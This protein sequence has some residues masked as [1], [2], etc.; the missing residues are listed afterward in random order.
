V[1]LLAVATALPAHAQGAEAVNFAAGIAQPAALPDD[2]TTGVIT[3]T[4][5]SRDGSVYEGVRVTLKAATSDPHPPAVRETTTSSSGSYSF[6]GIQPGPFE[7]TFSA[8]GFTHETRSGVLTPGNTYDL[9]PVTLSLSATSQVEV[10][11]TRDEIAT[12]QLHIEEEQ[13]VL[14]VIPNFYVVYTPNA[15]PLSSKQKFHLFWRTQIDPV[16]FAASAVTAGIQ[17]ARDDFPG[18]GQGAQ[19][20]F[21]RFGAD[22]ADSFIGNAI[23]G[24]I[25]P[26]LLKQDPRYF[27]LGRG[28]I[29]HRTLYAIANA[30]ICK[31]DNGRW[32]FNYSSIGGSLAA[33]GISNLYYPASDRNGAGLTFENMALGMA[34]GAIGNIFQEF[35]IPRL[36]PHLPKY[37]HQQPN[38]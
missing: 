22:Y 10:T 26:S 29:R 25:L 37:G 12:E 7:V 38:P 18:Y 2:P 14:G 9:P 34:G 23:G 20:Y 31:G 5:V 36:T 16:T 4:V 32:Q 28:T 27:Y 33:G 21:K 15:V 11:A 30:V 35:V 24:A 19:G 6:I 17:Q 8:T 1:F 13:R 3:G